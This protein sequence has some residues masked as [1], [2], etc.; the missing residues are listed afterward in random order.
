MF[1]LGNKTVLIVAF[2][3]FQRNSQYCV[4]RG[5][6]RRILRLIQ[7]IGANSLFG[8]RSDIESTSCYLSR[9]APRAE[10]QGENRQMPCMGITPPRVPVSISCGCPQIGELVSEDRDAGRQGFDEMRDSPPHNSCE[11]GTNVL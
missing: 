10:G 11:R 3:T 7:S 1:V 2:L 6:K 4:R 8:K 5:R 9:Q